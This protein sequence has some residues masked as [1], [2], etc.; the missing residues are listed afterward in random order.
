MKIN[1]LFICIALFLT[2]CASQ[3]V[4]ISIKPGNEGFIIGNGTVAAV[5]SHGLGASPFEV[6]GLAE[7]LAARNIAVYAVRLDG[8]GT[9]IEHLSKTKW[10]DWYESFVNEYE[11]ARSSHQKV[12]VGG[13]SLG[14]ELALRVAEENGVDGV[15][16]LAPSLILDDKRSNYAWLFKYFTKYSSRV[17]PIDRKPFYYDKFSVSAVAESVEL[18]KIV[19]RDLGEVNVPVLIMQYANDT[20]VDSRSPQ[21]VYDGISSQ[22]KELVWIDGTGHVFLLDDGKEKYFEKIYEFILENS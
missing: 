4:D 10:E 12:F 15:I 18:S 2:A 7:Y 9:S 11:I 14:G 19:E 13:M 21:I 20:R 16:A 3:P 8:H 17:I 1:T 22:R 5:L 6:K